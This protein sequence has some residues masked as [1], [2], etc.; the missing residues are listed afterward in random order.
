M[1]LIAI[2][3]FFPP[4]VLQ[5]TMFTAEGSI[6]LGGGGCSGTIDPRIPSRR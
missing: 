4:S 5:N 6:F 3:A 1:K 2:E